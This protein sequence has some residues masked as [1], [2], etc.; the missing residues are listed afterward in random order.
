VFGLEDPYV[1]LIQGANTDLTNS[2]YEFNSEYFNTEWVMPN[3][4]A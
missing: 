1:K 2:M 4:E 3:I